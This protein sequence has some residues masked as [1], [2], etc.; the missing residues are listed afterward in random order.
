VYNLE[1]SIS[2][3][4]LADKMSE[5][6]KIKVSTTI[7]AAL[8]WFEDNPK[9]TKPEYDDKQKEVDRV[10]N[11]D[12]QRVFRSSAGASSSPPPPAND[13]YYED[14]DSGAAAA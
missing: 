7:G 10:V 3:M 14:L 9:A 6:D 5:E 8:V 1:S 12:L 11:P 2:D 4:A 13:T